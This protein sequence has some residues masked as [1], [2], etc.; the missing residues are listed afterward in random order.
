M[1][2][3]PEPCPDFKPSGAGRGTCR[4]QLNRH[5]SL[6]MQTHFQLLQLAADVAALKCYFS[7]CTPLFLGLAAR[8]RTQAGFIMDVMLQQGSSI[9]LPAIEPPCPN[10]AMDPDLGEQALSTALEACLQL[11]MSK[12]LEEF[13]EAVREQGN[14]D[15]RALADAL[16]S[17]SRRVQAGLMRMCAVVL[18]SQSKL[19]ALAQVEKLMS[20]C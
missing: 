20:A 8:A 1:D 19:E 7:S 16:S 4:Q 9:A 6:I 5:L 12:K 18:H 14:N 13:S 15:V 17:E 11:E 10:L 3:E 2:D